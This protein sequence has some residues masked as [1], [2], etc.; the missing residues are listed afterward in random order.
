MIWRVIHAI[1]RAPELAVVFPQSVQECVAAAAGFKEISTGGVIDTCVCAV[2]GYHLAIRTPSKKEG[3]NVRSF[4]SGHYKSNGVNVQGACD[5]LCRFVFLGVAGPGSMPDRDAI[6]EV[7]L[8]ALIEKFEGYFCANADCAYTA[9]MHVVPVF[10]GAQARIKE[11]DNCNFYLSQCRIRIEMAFGMM[12]Q[13]FGILRSPL[14]CS[15]YKV[16]ELVAAIARLHNFCINERIAT[17]GY[18]GPTVGRI[19]GYGHSEEQQQLR[20]FAAIRE[21]QERFGNRVKICRTRQRF[22][23]AVKKARLVRPTI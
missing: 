8:S 2:D 5:H 6:Q 1:G 18:V 9:S 15:L 4:Y 16:K 10:G 23:D 21:Y 7:G 11:N 12:V 3:K 13:K 22:V 20:L 14:Q 19:N 17:P